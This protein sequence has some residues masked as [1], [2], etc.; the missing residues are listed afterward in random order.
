MTNEQYF[1]GFYE[2][3]AM[4]GNEAGPTIIEVPGKGPATIAAHPGAGGTLTV[5][6]TVSPHY[7]LKDNSARWIAAAIGTNGVVSSA[8]ATDVPSA[9]TAI[10]VEA[11]GA[12]GWLEL[13]Q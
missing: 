4:V 10:K 3:E 1:G 7:R 5:H 12:T 8:A 13:R 2:A 11:Q 9:I 6:F